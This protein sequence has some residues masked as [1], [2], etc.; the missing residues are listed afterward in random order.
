MTARKKP[1]VAFWATVGLVVLLLAYP[2]WYFVAVYLALSP[3]ELRALLR[4]R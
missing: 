1:G 2:L 3:D 4:N